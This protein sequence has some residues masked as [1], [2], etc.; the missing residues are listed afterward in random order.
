MIKEKK[1]IKIDFSTLPKTKRN[2]KD[3]IDWKNVAGHLIKGTYYNI[4]FVFNL[5]TLYF[6]DNSYYISLEYNNEKYTITN[7]NLLKLQIGHIFKYNIGD[8]KDSISDDINHILFRKVK[9]KYPIGFKTD[10]YKVVK[11]RVEAVTD[12]KIKKYYI[13]Q[14]LHTNELFNRIECNMKY[15]GSPF[16]Q[17][18]QGICEQNSLYGK[19]PDLHLYIK[20]LEFA[21]T[22]REHTKGTITTVCPNCK[23][24]RIRNINHFSIY[25]FSCNI[26]NSN[27]SYPE[28]LMGAVLEYNNINYEY[29][30]VFQDLPNRR[31]DFYLPESNTVIE[32]HGEQHY[33]TKKG[34]YFSYE[35]THNSDIIK[36]TFCQQYQINYIDIDCSKS[37]YDYIIYNIVENLPIDVHINKYKILEIVNNLSFHTDFK[38]IINKYQEGQS[39]CSIA[40]EYGKDPTS[41]SNFAKRAGVFKGRSRNKKVRCINTGEVY[42]GVREATRLVGLSSNASISL[43]CSNKNRTAG[44]HPITGE[45]LRWEYVD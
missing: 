30:K 11:Y 14:C 16:I 8:I 5:T 31:F 34:S 6:K 43:A 44:K 32:T 22:I 23:K 20:D 21:K 13:C 38:D 45:K 39:L 10:N 26:C 36:H 1:F 33:V 37:E 35:H 42:N 41:I 15:K 29:Q 17:G 4:D 28:R 24:E 12:T 18:T 19:R 3:A 7:G 9:F 27:I 25:G 2:G 40:K